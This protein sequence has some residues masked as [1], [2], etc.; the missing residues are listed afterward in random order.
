MVSR[1]TVGLALLVSLSIPGPVLAQGILEQVER[2]V[3]EVVRKSRSGVVTVEDER[4]LLSTSGPELKDLKG[5][6]PE[7]TVKKGEDGSKSPIKSGTGFAVG[8]GYIVTTADVLEGMQNPLVLTDSGTRYKARVVK[9]DPEL[10]IGLLKLPEKSGVASLPL[11]DSSKVMAGHFAISIG[12]Q[13]GRTNSVSLATI[14]GMLT[15]GVFSGSHFYPRLLQIS[16]SVGAGSSGSPLL[17]SRGEVVG[18]LAAAPVVEPI[19]PWSATGKQDTP[20]DKEGRLIMPFVAPT[21]LGFAIPINDLKPVI[22]EMRT[23]KFYARAWIGLDLREEGRVE[24]DPM[25]VRVMR[26]LRA[27]GIYPESPAARAGLRKGD[28]IVQMN[29]RPIR[30][31]ADFRSAILALRYD[32]PMVMKVSRDGKPVTLNIRFEMRPPLPKQTPSTE[33]GG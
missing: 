19:A 5:A 10:N 7:E 21:S 28:V 33:K 12:N 25:M 32:S 27:E 1:F 18:M 15:Q 6:P 11:G 17:N 13:S 20:R 31:L 26:T 4:I 3:S 2:E 8:D 9:I 29:E 22:E 14:S 30:S 23:A 16:G 24:Q